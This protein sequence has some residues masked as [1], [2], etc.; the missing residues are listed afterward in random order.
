M[1]VL[2]SGSR[3]LI[4]TALVAAL[5][6]DGHT[7]RRLVRGRAGGGEV[8]WDP[9]GGAIDHTGLEGVDAVVHLAGEP[10]GGRRWSPAQKERVRS[11]RVEGTRLLATALAELGRPPAVMVSGSA[12][13][14]Y[15]DRGEETLTE[16]ST[17][18]SGFLAEVC[19]RWEEA[20]GPAGEAGIRVVTIRTGVVLSPRGGAL[21]RQLPFFKLGIGG[22]LS[23]G[24]QYTSWISIDD[25]VGSVRHLLAT[26]SLKGPVNLTA[27]E[28]VR[29]AE[30]TRA[31]ARALHRP[32]VVPV[33]RFALAV[34]LGREL[35]A[36]MLGSQRVLPQRLEAS[37]YRFRHEQVDEALRHVLAA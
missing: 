4:G 2:V 10:I 31:L 21:G 28:P 11:S 24:R 6:A 7:V 36:E 27:P 29:N 15:G 19:R 35:A 32:A 3:G 9:A 34:V 14:I 20:T 1:L 37:G 25:H 33:P 23:S 18:G 22:R 5:E 13:G 17:L 12:V 8:G 30:L 16:D 26:E